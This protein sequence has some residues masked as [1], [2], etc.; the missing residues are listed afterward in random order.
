MKLPTL[1]VSLVLAGSAVADTDYVIDVSGM[2][3]AGCRAK[4]K[5][6]FAKL[7]GVKADS[8]RVEASKKKEGVNVIT[9]RSVSDKL[10]KELAV[11]SLGDAAKLYKVEQFTKAAAAKP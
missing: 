2:S 7:E 10:T 5:E 3:C 6:S 4:V 11:G 8:I 9:F 1:L